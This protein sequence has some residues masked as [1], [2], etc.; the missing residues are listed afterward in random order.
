MR[1]ET[2]SGAGGGAEGS[3]PAGNAGKVLTAL[4]DLGR[5]A[6]AYDLLDRLRPQGVS[7]PTTVYRALK[8][9]MEMRLV[10]RLEALN[11][12]VVCPH[13]RHADDVCLAVCEA[14]GR[15]D[16]IDDPLLRQFVDG[17][18]TAESFRL[19][20][21]AVELIGTCARCRQEAGASPGPADPDRR[22]E[23]DR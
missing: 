20:R 7:A 18:C 19:R 5:P 11:A 13:P 21:A 12:F 10:H 4:R 14:C 9:L 8:A 23:Q 3:E 17:W 1:R 22:A 15:V 16:E 2:G 6:S